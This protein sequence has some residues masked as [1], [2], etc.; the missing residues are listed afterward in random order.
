MSTQRKT[1]AKTIT[2]DINLIKKVEDLA[3]IENRNFSN[4]VETLLL[5]ATK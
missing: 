2:L 1:T 5:S 3:V 4:M